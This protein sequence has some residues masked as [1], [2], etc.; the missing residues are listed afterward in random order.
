MRVTEK[1]IDTRRDSEFVV[2]AHFLAAVEGK[3]KAPSLDVQV[4]L[5]R[6]MDAIYRS[7]AEGKEIV[8]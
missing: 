7:D 3:A 2:T 4:R 5:H 1:H 8:L 6:L